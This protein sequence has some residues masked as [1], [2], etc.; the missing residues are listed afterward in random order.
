[1]KHTSRSDLRPAFQFYPADWRSS[2]P[3]RMCSLSARGLWMEMLCIAFLSERRGYLQAASKPIP[4]G[5]LARMV[6]SPI[7]LVEE[8][9]KEL[10]SAGILDRDEAGIIQPS[11]NR[12]PAH[13]HSLRG[14]LDRRKLQQ[15]QYRTPLPGR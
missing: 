6:G 1:M 7:R 3:L 2:N 13:S 5:A 15:G 8:S 11:V 12:A 9:I 10:K 14:L 4:V